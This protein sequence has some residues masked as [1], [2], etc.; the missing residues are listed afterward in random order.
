[1]IDSSVRNTGEVEYN[2]QNR[3][4]HQ[5][6]Q[7]WRKKSNWGL[8]LVATVRFQL[9]RSITKKF[10]IE[11]TPERT[12]SSIRNLGEVEYD[13]QNWLQHHVAKLCPRWLQW[14]F[15]TF[16]WFTTSGRTWFLDIVGKFKCHIRLL[17]GF[18][19]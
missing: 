11:T 19:H 13:K 2:K 12:D 14:I 15:G 18:L 10:P 16:T 4:Q 3:L 6:T 7:A 8:P 5:E 1:M 17:Q 9:N